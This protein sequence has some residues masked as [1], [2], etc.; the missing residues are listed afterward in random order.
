VEQELLKVLEFYAPA[1]LERKLRDSGLKV[2]NC[3]GKG[4]CAFLVFLH[5]ISLIPDE[6]G[7]AQRIKEW[8]S[9][10]RE[11]GVNEVL[12]QQLRKE[13]ITWVM[14]QER[15]LGFLR[16]GH[17]IRSS[18]L[19]QHRALE[20]GNWPVLSDED[21]K[22]SLEKLSGLTRLQL[23]PLLQ[24]GDWDRDGGDLII[25]ILCFFF[26]VGVRIIDGDNATTENDRSWNPNPSLA[27]FIKFFEEYTDEMYVELAWS[28]EHPG[29]DLG[30]EKSV[31]LVY[32]RKH[33]H[34]QST[35][36]I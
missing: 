10:A 15:I 8:G 22:A 1:S 29:E 33:D 36:A 2:L 35:V 24:Q 12:A 3:G 16:A 30:S 4:Q 18:E 28:V 6:D 20:L 13:V 23:Q 32:S 34:W 21:K 31:I 5:Q 7:L 19:D 27:L 11:K 17:Q 26:G 14:D 25:F 9:R